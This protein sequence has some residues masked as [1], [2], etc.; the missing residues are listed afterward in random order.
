MALIK[1]T[2]TD[3]QF[4][5]E[6]DPYN[7]LTDNRPLEHLLN[8]DL[9]LNADLEA[10]VEEVVDARSGLT[11]DYDFLDNRL[12]AMEDAI[13]DSVS[14]AEV[15]NLQGHQYGHFLSNAEV[16]RRATPSGFLDSGGIADLAVGD[17]FDDHAGIRTTTSLGEDYPN[18]I[19]LWTGW[20]ATYRPI[21]AIINGWIVRLWDEKVGDPTTLA[22]N[23]VTI[24]L[25]TPPN[26]G[27]LI[28]YL[29][30]EVWL[31]RVS[32]T[33]PEFYQYGSVATNAIPATVD[34]HLHPAV[35]HTVKAMATGGDWI[36]VRHR[37]RFMPDVD[38]EYVTTHSFPTTAIAQGAKVA[39]VGGYTFTNMEEELNDAGLW[40][41][42][43]GDDTSK[44]ALGTYDGFVYAIPVVA[45][46]RWNSGNYAIS[47]QNGTRIDGV[48]LSGY[49]ASGRSGHPAGL[50]YDSISPID[51]LD[52]RNR[53]SLTG[54]NLQTELSKTW[55]MVTRG[56]L[57]TNWRE[58]QYDYNNDGTWEHASVWGHTLTQ[59]D[60]IANTAET[61]TH[62]IRD[63]AVT[64]APL[65]QPDGQRT[66]WGRTATIQTIKFS[67]TQGSNASASPPGFVTY[68][69]SQETLTFNAANL[70]G[71]GAGGTKVG[72][73]P[74][75]IMKRDALG[76]RP[77]LQSSGLGSQATSV[78]MTGLVA[79]APYVG[80]IQVVY[81][82]GSGIT[83][84]QKR[85]LTHEVVD[86]GVTKYPSERFGI[87]GTP[88]AG[89]TGLSS[90]VS[91]ARLTTGHYIV[92]DYGNQRIVKIDPTLPS[93]DNSLGTITAQFGITG[94]PGADN[95]HISWAYGVAT[96]S[97]DNI[98]VADTSNH[99]V[100]KLTSALAYAAQFG[101]TGISGADNTH[102]NQ[103][104]GVT[105][106]NGF[107][108]FTDHLNHRLVRLTTAMAYSGQF[109]VTGVPG[110]D[111]Y[112]LR[113]PR[114]VAAVATGTVS[115]IW[116]ADTTNNRIAVLNTDLS[117]AYQI[118]E[119]GPQ[120]ALSFDRV[121]DVARDALGNF[122][123]CL[124]WH[125]VVYKYNPS[126]A[127]VGQF[128][129]YGVTGTTNDRLQYPSGITLDNINGWLFVADSANHRVIRINAATMGYSTQFGVTGATSGYP[130]NALAADP[131]D[132]AVDSF[133]N[134][135]FVQNSVHTVTKLNSTMQF[136]SRV[137][138]YGIPG[139]PTE[140]GAF[141][142]PLGI[143]VKADGSMV[144]VIDA[145]NKR[146]VRLNGSLGW[147][148]YYSPTYNTAVLPR[149]VER[150]FDVEWSSSD[151]SWYVAYLETPS[152]TSGSNQYQHAISRFADT[153]TGTPN[154]LSRII[155][156]DWPVGI[157][158]TDTEII[159][160]T[161]SHGLIIHDKA[162][163][164]TYRFTSD[165]TVTIQ[166]RFVDP[167]GLHSDGS[168]VLVTESAAHAIHCFEA[169]AGLYRGTA[170]VM[171]EA[172]D[173]DARLRR[174]YHA[175]I[176]DKYLVV[177]DTSNHRI[178]RRHVSAPWAS[179]DGTI[180]T[181]LPPIGADR[182]RLFYETDSYQGML[183]YFG[184]GEAIFKAQVRAESDRLYATTLGLGA[185]LSAQL[186]KY[187]YLRGMT[188]R[189]P[190]PA[191]GWHDFLIQP[192]GMKVSIQTE[193][194]DGPY[195][196]LPVLVS[197][198]LLGGQT[199]ITQEGGSTLSSRQTLQQ[200]VR[201]VAGS[202]NPRV[203]GFR[204]VLPNDQVRPRSRTV[205]TS[206]VTGGNQIL[207]RPVI[208][209]GR[210]QVRT[211]SYFEVIRYGTPP[212]STSPLFESVAHFTYYPFLYQR[213]GRLLMG[214][215]ASGSYGK[216]VAVGHPEWN[217][218]DAFFP[219]GRLLVR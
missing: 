190:L 32:K 62:P 5:V 65:A 115:G 57:R 160:G 158:I 165:P 96:D 142:N 133:G 117:F 124:K 134:V 97:G 204:S 207:F 4:F 151:D 150:L 72:M 175:M 194:D 39:P 51:V 192:V 46:H 161:E 214:V 44:T 141:R 198:G 34:D 171:Y 110:A 206:V 217:A 163:P 159:A 1:K 126:L 213:R 35:V 154:Y 149:Q 203:R 71:A 153:P 201:T 11:S 167:F 61:G 145:G 28:N 9:L 70:S 176:H 128:G 183:G 136:V 147:L 19:L 98:Y 173:D 111:R 53:I 215:I 100:L 25:G 58:L 84:P 10:L 81:P 135:Y 202:E 24:D 15:E 30:L 146:I 116:V 189:L 87:T 191:G 47:N 152:G 199:I 64:G 38:G 157:Y 21:R 42:G 172:G 138:V 156:Y 55:E 196:A 68:N 216:E 41:S 129:M 79:A 56:E 127:L 208:G 119:F 132:V 78:R 144:Q 123:I 99:R 211:E 169:E 170:G 3:C 45:V 140:V 166:F 210:T 113:N 26:T 75:V 164:T 200:I 94:V 92:A 108:Y 104:F 120:N 131:A 109:G 63:R 74:P 162:N 66:Q 16:V 6:S 50:F 48:A 31:E 218:V 195:L 105:A 185:P 14:V 27:K 73:T 130:L 114:G 36:Q 88:A 121:A 184:G 137:G 168:R 60:Q 155:S 67:F 102:C 90:P 179:T 49:I 103:P 54:F 80:F 89:T 69:A 52:L 95:T 139:N 193:G 197:E 148:G 177:V 143:A 187:A 178:L 205:S 212:I 40:R 219:F 82:G 118:A 59:I 17:E 8:N 182:V 29:F 20:G 112:G 37:L 186:E 107:V 91:V 86:N 101:V 125:H 33:S 174:P 12:D 76:N 18:T 209:T 106:G 93:G 180:S 23:H 22:L 85:V 83:F 2:P 13:G 77:T 7:Y 122:Y 188:L 43:A 181:M